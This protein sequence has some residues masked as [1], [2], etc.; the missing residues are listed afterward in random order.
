MEADLAHSAHAVA[1]AQKVALVAE[2][3]LVH[4]AI[5]RR[6]SAG[7]AQLRLDDTCN[8][9]AARVG[10]L[11]E[12]AER[13]W[14][15]WAQLGADGKYD[16]SRVVDAVAEADIICIQETVRG[17]RTAIPTRPPGSVGARAAISAST[18]R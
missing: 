4:L 9:N 5:L 12:L 6:I 18:G 3:L 7:D 16:V 15:T 13:V 17:R 14:S 1:H 2:H 11:T 8:G 10:N